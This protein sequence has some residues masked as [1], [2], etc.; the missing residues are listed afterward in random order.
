MDWKTKK[1]K[2]WQD[3]DVEQDV[4]IATSQFR[5]ESGLVSMGN[6]CW[7]PRASGHGMALLI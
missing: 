5:E 7:R 3:I 6:V 2:M 1:T 4:W